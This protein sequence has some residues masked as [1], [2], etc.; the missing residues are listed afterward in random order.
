MQYHYVYIYVTSAT[1]TFIGGCH[2]GE[3][4]EHTETL[5]HSQLCA[6]QAV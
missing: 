6:Q 5:L 1:L 3:P 2:N 4:A